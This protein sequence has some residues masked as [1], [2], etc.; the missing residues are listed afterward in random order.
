MGP[1]LAGRGQAGVARPAGE[2]SFEDMKLPASIPSEALALAHRLNRSHQR[3]GRPFDPGIRLAPPHGVRSSWAH[4]G[5]M[6]PGLPEPHRTFGV[7]SIV[8]TPGVAVFDNDHAITTSGSDTAY[9]VS[10]TA[11]MRDEGLHTYSIER[12]CEFHPDGSLVRFGDDLTIEGVYP[13]FALRRHHPEVDVEL[14]I[15]ATDKV[16]YFA[17]L[18]GGMYT[19]WS[20]L[21]RYD[22]VLG[23]LS[24]AGLCTLEYATGFGRHSVPLLGRRNLPVPFFT[25]QVLNIDDSTQV[26]TTQVLAA[27]GLELAYATYVRGLDD[28]GSELLDTTFDVDDYEPT[29]RQTP[30]GREMRLPANLHWSA[31]QNGS[32]V[33]SVS[34]RCHGDWV[35]GLGAG[36]VGSYAYTGTFRGEKIGGTAYIEYIDLR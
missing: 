36:F 21:C 12:D 24:V 4:Y 2:A 30:A 11:A 27:G 32:E 14:R 33:I 28:Y 13:D 1:T 23:G 7:M 26:M 6:V 5:V 35:Y 10:A 34:G 17:D 18:V 29:P 15:R 25:Y 16:T 31:R 8:G 9:L 20:L 3:I 19:H 22:G